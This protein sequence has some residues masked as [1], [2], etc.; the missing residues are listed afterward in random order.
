MI[1]M[2]V[3]SHPHCVL[4]NYAV[5][6]TCHKWMFITVS[7]QNGSE[8]CMCTACTFWSISLSSPILTIHFIKYPFSLL[9]KEA[10]VV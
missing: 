5:L 8:K 1:I 10:H 9:V 3:S 7:E 6:S 2:I 4:A